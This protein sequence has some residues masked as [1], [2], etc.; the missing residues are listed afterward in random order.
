MPPRA[1]WGK[2]GVEGLVVML[3]TDGRRIRPVAGWAAIACAALLVTACNSSG[4]PAV[5]ASSSPARAPGTA[6]PRAAASTFLAQGQ[7][8]NGP[9]LYR[10]ACDGSGCALS[11]DSTSFLA[12]M[13]WDTW[14]ATEAVGTGT[15][16]VDGCDP[17][18]AAGPVY[19][20]ATVVT[21]SDP[22]RVCSASGTRWVWTRA[23]FRYPDGLPR[24]LRGGSSPENPWVF[25]TVAAAAQQSCAR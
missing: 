24:A 2:S 12:K 1:Q 4:S 15:Y 14:S 18:C 20:V 21:L 23:S 13:T 3:I 11:G 22:V 9:L 10:P 25:S 5:A 7:D 19:P 8:I 16:Q 17:D 6:V